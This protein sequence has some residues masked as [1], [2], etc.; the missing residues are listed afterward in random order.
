MNYLDVYWARAN[1]LGETTGERIRNSNI[2]SFEKWLDQSPY[3]VRNLSVERGLY[4]DGI[5]EENKDKEHKKIMFLNVAN[6]IPLVI[7]D[8]MNWKLDNGEVEKWLVHQ[9][10]KKT[11]PSHRTFWIIRCNYL[12]KWVDLEGHVKQS[13]SYCT[14]SLDSMIKGN[15]RTWHNVIA[16]QPNKY[17]EV[18]MP[19]QTPEIFRSTN[20]IVE[21]EL[22]NIV[23]YDHTSVPGVTYF[24]LTEGKINSLTDD[25]ENNLA[26]TDKIAQ[27][28]LSMPPIS[29]IF[30]LGDHITPVFTLTKNGVPSNEEVV[31]ETTDKKVVRYINGILIA[32]GR[33]TT[34]LV[35]R[36]K[37]HPDIT[38]SITITV[39]ENV[40]PE[41]SAYIEGQDKLK[42][43]RATT[44]VFKGTTALDTDVSFALEETLLASIIDF[45]SDSCTIKANADNK[46]GTIVLV[47]SYAGNQYTKEIKIIP[48]W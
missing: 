17:L 9:E 15:F 39:G 14:S 10:E 21:E 43:N 22:W 41:F 23:D 13:W 29:Q 34:E 31:L 4:F 38:Q 8:I 5:I 36:L 2:R 1:H 40:E 30:N 7:G 33:G 11:N 32:V 26:D 24:S 18:L 16:A 48:L 35:A 44:Y 45:T 27:Y 42:L 47:A 6:D 46:L 37:E 19:R 3:T 25:V 20:F 12:L 28:D